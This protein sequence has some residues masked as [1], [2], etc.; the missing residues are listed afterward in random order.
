[1]KRFLFLCFLT[2][3]LFS[4]PVTAYAAEKKTAR[5]EYQEAVSDTKKTMLENSIA[6][7]ELNAS[8]KTYRLKWQEAKTAGDVPEEAKTLVKKIQELRKEFQEEN[9]SM[10]PYR[11]A[12]KACSQALNSEGAIAAME[13][14]I[15]IQEYRLDKKAEINKLWKQVCDLV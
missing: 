9:E 10:E 2:A 3:C 7:D 1:M 6:L 15:R 8:T 11:E 14:I 4:L 13:N 5:E 12:K